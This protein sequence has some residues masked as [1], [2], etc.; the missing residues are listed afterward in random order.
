MAEFYYDIKSLFHL[1][2]RGTQVFEYE[3]PCVH[4]EAVRDRHKTQ[5]AIRI[6]KKERKKETSL[7]C[8]SSPKII[9]KQP[10][11]FYDYCNHFFFTKNTIQRGTDAEQL[12]DI[13]SKC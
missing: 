1:V 2:F 6:L 7:M 10:N 13:K 9:I 12:Q 8:R 3:C 11:M 4:L 5:K